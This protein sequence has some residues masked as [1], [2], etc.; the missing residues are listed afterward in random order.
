[1]LDKA[2]PPELAIA[3]FRALFPEGRVTQIEHAAHFC[4]EDAAP[5]LVELIKQ[6]MLAHPAS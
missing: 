1:M 2:I 5:E 4:Q 6:F 3:D